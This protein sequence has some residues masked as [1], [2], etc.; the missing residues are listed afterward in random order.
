MIPEYIAYEGYNYVRI[1]ENAFMAAQN[2]SYSI[3]VI[4]TND[5]SVGGIIIAPCIRG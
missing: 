3:A 5:D 2:E 1:K 4:R